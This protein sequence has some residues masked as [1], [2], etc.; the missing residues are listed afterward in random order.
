MAGMIQLGRLDLRAVATCTLARCWVGTATVG[1]CEEAVEVMDTV[2]V[3]AGDGVAGTEAAVAAEGVTALTTVV[4]CG[5][6]DGVLGGIIKS[7]SGCGSG[8]R[9]STA[10]ATSAVTG[11]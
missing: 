1:A 11:S 5:D 2:E 9:S 4:I 6:L 8:F 3:V 10:L 7:G